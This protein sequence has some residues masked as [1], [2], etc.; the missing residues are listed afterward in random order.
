MRA[1]PIISRSES[2]R[3]LENEI[4][5]AALERRACEL[6]N[7]TAEIRAEIMAQIDHEVREEL[8]RRVRFADWLRLFP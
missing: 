4:R 8:R 7:A 5:R 6:K 3:I 2:L 1:G